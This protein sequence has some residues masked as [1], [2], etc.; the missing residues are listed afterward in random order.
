MFFEVKDGYVQDVGPSPE[1]FMGS[2]R[3]IWHILTFHRYF[4]QAGTSKCGSNAASAKR[5]SS[6]W[7]LF[8]MRCLKEKMLKICQN[9]V[10]FWAVVH[11]LKF[12]FKNYITFFSSGSQTLYKAMLIHAK[13]KPRATVQQ[14]TKIQHTNRAA[15]FRE[16]SSSQ[17]F[18]SQLFYICLKVYNLQTCLES[19]GRTFHRKTTN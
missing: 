14:P 18:Q 9:K 8:P 5:S 17:R 1:N 4:A 11:P 13:N 16:S 3:T 6:T 7:L 15:G 2:I 12:F 10:L 19:M